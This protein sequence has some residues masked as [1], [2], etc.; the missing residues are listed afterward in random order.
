MTTYC[1]SFFFS[2]KQA[3]FCIIIHL[4]NFYVFLYI[5]FKSVLKYQI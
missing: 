2:M 3:N 1:I 4:V 5:I